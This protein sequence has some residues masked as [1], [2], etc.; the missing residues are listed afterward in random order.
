MK[1]NNNKNNNKNILIVNLS[2]FNS[3][4]SYYEF[5][6][7]IEKIIKNNFNKNININYIHYL[8]IEK[9]NVNLY[10]HIIFSGTYLKDFNY[11]NN[12]KL[13]EKLKKYNGKFL[14]ICSGAH[15]L[16]LIEGEKLMNCIKIGFEEIIT[17]DKSE[18]E[19]ILKNI[20]LENKRVYELHNKCFKKINK[21]KFE[22]IL[23]SSNCI[24]LFKLKNKDFYG[25]QFHP[26]V[27]LKEIIINFINM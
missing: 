23:K 11:L 16:G 19:K 27:I 21:N 26:E 22:I 18:K 14:G 3:K 10:S 15:I 9:I 13:F 1:M 8:E 25:V 2:N 24:E 12:L 20:N 7:P 5:I 17:I 6:K 4:F